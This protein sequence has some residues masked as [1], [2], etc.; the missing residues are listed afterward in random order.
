MASFMLP[1]LMLLGSIPAFY[2]Q[3]IE[4]NNLELN[5]NKPNIRG[6]KVGFI[7]NSRLCKFSSV[8]KSEFANLCVAGFLFSNFSM[9]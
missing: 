7:Q 6:R 4:R 3:A 1:L 9:L 5:H 2:G 8:M